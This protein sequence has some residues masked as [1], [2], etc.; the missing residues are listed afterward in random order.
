[1]KRVTLVLLG[2]LM[3]SVVFGQA[4]AG[5]FSG[6]MFGDYYYV[7]K[8]HDSSIEDMN[9]VQFRRIYFTY[10]KGLS[11]NVV[12]RLRLEFNNAGDFTTKA[13]LS[14]VVKDAYLSWKASSN[15][16]VELGISPTPT[17]EVVEKAWGYRSVE[18]TP[19]D[20]QMFG[21]SRDFGV[22]VKGN[23]DGD[24]KVK[25]H[26]MV[27]NGNSISS[28][29]NKGKKTLGSIGFYPNKNLILE[30][31]GD[32]NSNDGEADWYTYHAFACI[33]NS[34]MRLGVLYSQQTRQIAGGD[35]L[36]LSLAS[37]FFVTKVSEKTNLLARVDRMFDPN[38]KGNT[39]AYIPFDKTAKSTFL[40]VGL[41]FNPIESVHWMPNV[42]LVKYDENE[43]GITPDTDIIPRLTFY[44]TF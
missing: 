44:Y 11:E 8:N 25:Y 40:L 36:S 27:A 1:M 34:T 15:V 31:Y 38:P 13:K 18:K 33:K 43:A 23:L 6:Y 35:D 10:D 26:V 17:W 22:A 14:P 21:S 28:E 41:D 32:W 20:L 42:E 9:G 19:L 7:M 3:C 24:G 37:V 4:S 2:L 39:I 12:T 5:K 29:T 16:Q 30:F